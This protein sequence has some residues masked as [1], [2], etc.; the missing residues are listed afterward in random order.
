MPRAVVA[1]HAADLQIRHDAILSQAGSFVEFHGPQLAEG[2]LFEPFCKGQQGWINVH[3]N[4][5]SA[6]F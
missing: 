4:L 5:P 6:A 1:V 2:V 3:P